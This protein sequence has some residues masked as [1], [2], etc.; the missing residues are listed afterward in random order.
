MRATESAATPRSEA[1]P[2]VWGL[3]GLWSPHLGP[4][5]EPRPD[6]CPQREDTGLPGPLWCSQD[7]AG[8]GQLPAPPRPQDSGPPD[9]GA[10]PGPPPSSHHRHVTMRTVTQ[11]GA[12]RRLQSPQGAGTSSGGCCDLTKRH[13]PSLRGNTAHGPPLSQPVD[14][15]TS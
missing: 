8:Q 4:D 6:P 13:A 1:R 14:L 9:R 11:E 7:P 5:T 2:A 10:A 3:R 12:G 15:Q